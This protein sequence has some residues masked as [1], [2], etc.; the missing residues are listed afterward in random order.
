MI[1]ISHFFHGPS[2]GRSIYVSSSGITDN[3]IISIENEVDLK[4]GTMLFKE[5]D[6]P[7]SVEDHVPSRLLFIKNKL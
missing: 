3:L 5:S 1:A 6:M 7:P 2:R 4:M